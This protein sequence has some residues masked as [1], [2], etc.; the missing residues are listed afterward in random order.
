[1]WLIGQHFSKSTIA[2]I[3]SA[4]DGEPSLSRRALSRRVCEWLDWRAPN[5]KPK[6]GSCRK[7]LV[8]LDRKGLV[9]LPE[10]EPPR[11]LRGPARNGSAAPPGLP[12]VR[13]DLD[14]LGTITVEPV[15]DRRS[16]NA[17][18]WK[19]LMERF[20]YL[21]SGPLCGGQMRYLFHSSRH[22]WLG[23]AAFS[24]AVWSTRARDEHI[25]WSEAARRANL[26][27]VVN[28][29]RLLILPGVRVPNLASYALGRCLKRLARDWSS[30]YGYHPLL[31]ETFVDPSR[32]T[33]ACYRAAN[34]DCAGRTKSRPTPFSNGRIPDGA[35]D[36]YVRPIH[37]RWKTRLCRE[38]EVRPGGTPRPDSPADW[39]EEE[40]AAVRF[41]DRRLT[42]RLLG[43]ARDFFAHP[44]S[45]VPEACGG[46]EAKTKAA[47]RFFANSRVT[48]ETLIQPHV[49]STIERIRH[50]RVVLAVQDTTTLNYTSHAPS[51]S[52]PV[53]GNKD[54]ARGLLLHD[55]MAFTAEGTPLGL[56]D[57]QC[58][59]REQGVQRKSRLRHDLPVERKESVKWLNSLRAAGRAR[60]LCPQTRVVSV[61]DREADIHELFHEA[62]RGPEAPDLLIRAERSRNRKTEQQNLWEKMEAQPAAGT[63]QVRVPAKGGTRARTATL[64]VCFSKVPLKSPRKSDLPD[65]TVWAVHAREINHGAEVK[66]P[67]EWMLLTTVP[68]EDFE[69]ACERM[70]WYAKRWGIEVYHRTLKSG[71]R[72]QDRRLHNAGGLKAC[73]A[74]DMVVAW[75][76]HR[77][78]KAGR[79]SPDLSCGHF[80]EQR[81]WAAL[82]SWHTEQPPPE[83]PPTVLQASRWIAKLGGWL[84]RNNDG[85]PGTTTLWR[86][87][88]K[89]AWL[90]EGSQLPGN[91]DPIRA[92]P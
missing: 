91:P 70:D 46:S 52:G 80:L 92:G 4:V 87:L 40:F 34:W 29:S 78:V 15:G 69:G 74:V 30:R 61:G 90:V 3:Q 55:T 72:I 2:A 47:Y 1:M 48:M 24:G 71:C 33:G 23:G 43:L 65:I 20:H 12:D 45:L 75:R 88:T 54:Q 35:K 11:G 41:F 63:R 79:E 49:E 28:N 50:E 67:L 51:G 76:V 89:L 5:G 68:T 82:A 85:E 84:G 58:W 14:D 36:I 32:F 27:R 64:R 21:G 86:G 83:E 18:I 8:E 53:N 42:G 6:E 10:A 13:A 26:S 37:R 38:P 66:S 25:G 44:G 59:A 31:V 19:S 56:L 39:A 62:V 16:K 57:V 60:A 7:A 73:L 17:G 81:E 77:L 9:E 22:G